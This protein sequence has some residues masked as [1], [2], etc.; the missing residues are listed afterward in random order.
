MKK[1]RVM[2]PR[3]DVREPTTLMKKIKRKSK[4]MIEV[5]VPFGVRKSERKMLSSNQLA[6]C[7]VG[8]NLAYLMTAKRSAAIVAFT[9]EP[10]YRYV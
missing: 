2:A 1:V 10:K 5:A 6:S 3:E 9:E 4:K 8:P 7:V